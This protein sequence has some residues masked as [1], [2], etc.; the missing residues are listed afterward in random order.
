MYVILSSL[1]V[2]LLGHCH[3]FTFVF[4][5]KNKQTNKLHTSF[6]PVGCWGLFIF[7]SSYKMLLHFLAQRVSAMFLLPNALSSMEK[8]SRSS[9]RG[10]WGH[11]T[12]TGGMWELPALRGSGRGP[13]QRFGAL[14]VPGLGAPAQ[15]H[16]HASRLD[17][18]GSCARSRRRSPRCPAEGRALRRLSPRPGCLQGGTRAQPCWKQPGTSS[19]GSEE[20]GS[21]STA[22]PPPPDTGTLQSLIPSP[23]Q[24]RVGNQRTAQGAVWARAKGGWCLWQIMILC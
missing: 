22:V 16:G 13:G 11:I 12:L 1:I 23:L 24:G 15:R 6:C 21:C 7:Q 9:R 5:G 10:L 8:S 2:W 4:G 3:C 20:G 14:G 17:S 19:T 18:S